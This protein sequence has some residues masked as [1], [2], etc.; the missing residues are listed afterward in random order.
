MFDD[1]T[2]Q[3]VQ[4]ATI[5]SNQTL[6]Y[7]SFGTSELETWNCIAFDK[8]VGLPDHIKVGR[9]KYRPSSTVRD[10]FF[11]YNAITHELYAYSNNAA[12]RYVIITSSHFIS[13]SGTN[14]TAYRITT[15]PLDSML[16]SSLE[17]TSNLFAAGS[18]NSVNISNAIVL[19][20]D[21]YVEYSYTNNDNSKITE[22]GIAKITVLSSG[23]CT[24][25]TILHNTR[26]LSAT[27]MRYSLHFINASGIMIYGTNTYSVNSGGS[28]SYVKSDL[29]CFNLNT[30]T[31]ISTSTGVSSS[32]LHW[33]NLI[34]MFNGRYY[35]TW[36]SQ[37]YV[38]PD[39]ELE[40]V[41]N[42]ITTSNTYKV[43]N[44]NEALS[45]LAKYTQPRFDL[46]TRVCMDC[47]VDLVNLK[48]SYI[49]ALPVQLTTS[50]YRAF[51]DSSDGTLDGKLGVYVSSNGSQYTIYGDGLPQV[52]RL[53]GSKC[54]M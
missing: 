11:I 41:S 31:L 3:W 15:R 43:M 14:S 44:V 2:Q 1:S 4:T 5:T 21:I 13:S 28:E 36:N 20:N 49:A 7:M 39:D 48:V 47:I 24:Y 6:G 53:M 46:K 17:H 25:T 26:Q 8:S 23:S 52:Y 22:C 51:I 42:L 9:C 45:K 16:D 38:V 40:A 35:V 10:Y 34:A 54:T 30:N 19:G 33:D 50:G 32:I 27:Y 12:S 18:G 29:N 37:L